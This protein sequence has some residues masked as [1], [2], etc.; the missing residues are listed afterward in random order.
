MV[1]SDILDE[2]EPS[3]DIDT[4]CKITRFERQ[5]RSQ[6]IDIFMEEIKGKKYKET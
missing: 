1:I 6:S 4:T 2:I 5:C 3:S